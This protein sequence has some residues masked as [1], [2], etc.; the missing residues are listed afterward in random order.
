M[1]LAGALR[2]AIWSIDPDQ[3]VWKVRSLDSLL[4]RDMAGP[5]FA[6]VLTAAFALLALTLAVVGVYGVM[7]FT[8]AQRT[9]EVGVRM[10]LG[11]RRWDVTRMVLVQGGRVVLVSLGFGLLGALAA[12]RLIRKQ[13]FGVSAAD[14]VALVGVTIGLGLVALA[15]CY[16]PA[17]RAARVDPVIALRAE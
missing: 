4:E 7:S 9:H 11:A 16:L 5:R 2:S 14:P 12:G 13:L 3:P 8:V 17:R 6:V 10:A 15:A 1:R